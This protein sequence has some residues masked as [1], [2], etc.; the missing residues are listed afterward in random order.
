MAFRNLFGLA[1]ATIRL[2]PPIKF[3]QARNI[4]IEMIGPIDQTVGIDGEVFRT[5][6]NGRI[7]VKFHSQINYLKYEGR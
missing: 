2:N 7:E 3:A 4:M 6:G 5:Q 1:V